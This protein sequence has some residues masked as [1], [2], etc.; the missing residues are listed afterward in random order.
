LRWE[1]GDRAALRA[2]HFFEE[3]RRVAEQ[4]KA[5][6]GHDFE[7]FL[8]LVNE[9]GQSSWALLQNCFSCMTPTVQSIP[10]A[11]TLSAQ[12]LGQRGAW[13]V[14]GGGF[15]GTVQVF[16]P[17]DLLREYVNGMERVFG[18]GACRRLEVRPMGA[19]R[20]PVQK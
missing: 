12:I 20:F 18:R 2:F 8:V 3:N 9:S 4:V 15:A 16:V 1:V 11:L 7:R 13:R 10:L 14:H 17:R 19:V 5:L 6:N